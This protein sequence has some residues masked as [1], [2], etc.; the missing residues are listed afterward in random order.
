MDKGVIRSRKIRETW[1]DPRYGVAYP[2]HAGDTTSIQTY[3]PPTSGRGRDWVL[4]LDDAT[5]GFG[6][7][8]ASGNQ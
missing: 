8:G 6:E 1:F 4:I 2:L 5:A 7:P 3:T